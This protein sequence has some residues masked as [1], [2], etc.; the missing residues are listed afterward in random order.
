MES[1]Q[2]T[3]V[4]WSVFGLIALAIAVAMLA[5]VKLRS[6]RN[7]VVRCRQW[8][9]VTGR[10]TAVGI[11]EASAPDG[12]KQ[13]IPMVVYRYVAGDIQYESEQLTIGGHQQYSLRRNAERRLSRYVVGRPVPVHVDPNDHSNAVLECHSPHVPVLWA[14]LGLIVVVMIGGTAMLL[15]TPGV[16]GPE[17]IVNV[18]PVLPDW[19]R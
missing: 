8:T 14:M 19:L 5:A 11:R 13:F 12:M 6:A 17:P 1:G 2:T 4:L 16:A 18:D 3:M 15:L 10:V 7:A 9:E